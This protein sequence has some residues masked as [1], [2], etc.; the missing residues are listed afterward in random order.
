MQLSRGRRLA[1]A[2]KVDDFIAVAGLDSGIG[3]LRARENL[4]VTFD[5][6]ATCG[7]IQVAE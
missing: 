4:K 1:A 2:Y 7:E 3:P 5:G 6:D